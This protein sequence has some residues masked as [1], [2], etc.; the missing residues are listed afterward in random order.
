MLTRSKGPNAR[1]KS[2]L[3][4]I[5]EL[6]I[7]KQKEAV[8]FER[9]AHGLVGGVASGDVNQANAAYLHTKS[10]C[11]GTSPISGYPRIEANKA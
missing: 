6:L 3:H 11:S 10:G 9:G 2:R 1:E 7:P 5:T 8:I 4:V